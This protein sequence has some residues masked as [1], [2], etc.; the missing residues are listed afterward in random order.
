VVIKGKSVVKGNVTSVDSPLPPSGPDN[1]SPGEGTPIRVVKDIFVSKGFSSAVFGAISGDKCKAMFPGKDAREMGYD[2]SENV[3][4]CLEYE[5][6]IYPSGQDKVVVLSDAQMLFPKR[7]CSTL[8]NGWEQVPGTEGRTIGYCQK[9]VEISYAASQGTLQ[10]TAFMFAVPL[11][12]SDNPL[13][14]IREKI[15]EILS[16]FFDKFDALEDIIPEH[17]L[18]NRRLDMVSFQ[19]KPLKDLVDSSGKDR[20]VE[21]IYHHGKADIIFL[22]VRPLYPFSLSGAGAPP[23]V[24]LPPGD[25]TT[26]PPSGGGPLPRDPF[27][28]DQSADQEHPFGGV[29]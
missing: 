25:P 10:E 16:D 24:I 13:K 23:P 7:A 18:I 11:V 3:L 14:N 19:L 27:V 8:G 22:E 26:P 28:D 15:K 5:N 29:F 21:E 4:W 6:V 1:P 2:G 9:P 20:G 17:S 12:K